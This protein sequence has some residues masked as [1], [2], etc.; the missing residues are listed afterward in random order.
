MGSGASKGGGG[1]KSGGAGKGDDFD[2]ICLA[3]FRSADKDGSGALGKSF[4]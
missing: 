2:A 3:V 4:L 1:V